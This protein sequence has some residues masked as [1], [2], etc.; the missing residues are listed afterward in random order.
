MT[1]VER[2]PSREAVTRRQPTLLS[3]V[4]E[5]VWALVSAAFVAAVTAYRLYALRLARYPG[6][7]D[8]AFY[9]N[10]A[11]NLDAGRGPKIDYIWEFLTGQPDLPR[12]AFDYW[13]PLPSVLMWI[14]IHIHQ[15][16]AS[17]LTVNI[18]MSVLL[19]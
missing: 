12:Y 15:G 7:A 14:A 1:L 4:P 17:A 2:S 5:P 16:L 13:L 3:G 18:A 11:Q 9:Y 6:H 8:P 10:V 19:A